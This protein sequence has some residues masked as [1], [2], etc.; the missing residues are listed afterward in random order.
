MPPIY[1]NEF[2]TKQPASFPFRYKGSTEGSLLGREG[3]GEIKALN[4]ITWKFLG[5]LFHGVYSRIPEP[6]THKNAVLDCHCNSLGKL[7][8]SRVL[9]HY[10]KTAPSR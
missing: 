4:C 5:R 1:A 9:R 2:R 10:K 6:K 3:G 8:K 7:H